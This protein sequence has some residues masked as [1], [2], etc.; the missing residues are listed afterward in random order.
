MNVLEDEKCHQKYEMSVKMAIVGF[1]MLLFQQMSGG[2][3]LTFH[4]EEI[5][6]SYLSTNKLNGLV[7]SI[8]IGIYSA[9]VGN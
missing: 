4:M 3:T 9:Q 2:N 1:G 6:N 5:L 8:T 7:K